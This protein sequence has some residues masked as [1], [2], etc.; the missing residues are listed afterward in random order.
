MASTASF[1]PRTVF[2][3]LDSIIKSYYLGHHK[4]GLTKMRQLLS[5][6]E[7]IIEC[8]DY[9][10]PLSSRNPMFEKHLIGRERMI[11]YTKRDLGAE[12]LDQKTRENIRRWHA[13]QKVLFTDCKTDNDIKKV[14]NYA[15]DIARAVDSLTGTRMMLT[16]MP[17]VGKSSLLN[18]LR[19]VG[20][21]KGKV[22]ITGGQP[23][24]TRNI[25]T[26][27]RISS[28]PSILLYD[29][30][31]VFIP[32][33]PNESTMLKLAL[34]GCVKDTLIDP[35]TLCDYLLFRINMVNPSL[36]AAYHPPTNNIT[37]LLTATALQTGRLGKGGVPDI[38]ATAI[39]LIQRYRIGELGRFILDDVDADALERRIEEESKEGMSANQLRKGVKA[40]RAAHRASKANID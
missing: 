20:M 37:E 3:R 4:A 21:H 18:A 23:G 15:K 32:Y 11:V 13:P 25:G 9:R 29:T 39:W 38:T 6:V 8:R 14:I 30:P 22:A 33:V 31:G 12:S 10:V 2:P 36:Y 1:V 7:L 28:D 27:V 19:R 24:V 26:T 16:G 17:N 5:S 35:V 40:E 34:V